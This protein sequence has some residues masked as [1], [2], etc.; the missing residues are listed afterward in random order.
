MVVLQ[1]LAELRGNILRE[2]NWILIG[3]KYNVLIAENGKRNT[4]VG[5]TENY[6][7][8][9]IKENV[10]IGGKKVGRDNRCNGHTSCR[11]SYIESI[12]LKPYKLVMKT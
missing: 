7:H 11:K 1:T 5:I 12:Y 4:F 8:V 2:K 3:R 6:K 10:N 9:V